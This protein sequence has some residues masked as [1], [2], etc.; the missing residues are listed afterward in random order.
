MDGLPGRGQ[1]RHRAGARAADH[2][3]G[4][5]ERRGHVV[6]E[7]HDLALEPAFGELRRQRCMRRRRSD[8]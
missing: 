6:D 4:A 5:R 1:F 7:R 2:Q 8:G 3:V